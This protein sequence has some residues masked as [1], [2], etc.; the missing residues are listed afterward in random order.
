M[1]VNRE[2]ETINKTKKGGSS[3]SPQVLIV[4]AL[5]VWVEVKM[6]GRVGRSRWVGG[7]QVQGGL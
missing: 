4:P 5:H 1:V 3:A 7:I 6:E 2:Q